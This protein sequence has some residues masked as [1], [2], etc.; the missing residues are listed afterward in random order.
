[1]LKLNAWLGK[2]AYL[3][4]LTFNEWV[5]RWHKHFNSQAHN[6]LFQPTL[7]LLTTLS[8]LHQYQMKTLH[9]SN[10]GS[11]ER[12][13][14][15]YITAR[16]EVQKMATEG[17]SFNSQIGLRKD[18][19]RFNNKV[20]RIFYVEEISGFCKFSFRCVLRLVLDFKIQFALTGNKLFLRHEGSW[21]SLKSWRCWDRLWV[22]WCP[23]RPWFQ[24][25]FAPHSVLLKTRRRIN[26]HSV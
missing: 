18:S 15:V 20:P 11:A 12:Y 13:E 6:L 19:I 8:K 10:S 7:D 4:K 1:M 22:F 3:S 14:E 16:T 9:K 25:C 23:L 24:F 5:T 26:S 2:N 21:L 17:N